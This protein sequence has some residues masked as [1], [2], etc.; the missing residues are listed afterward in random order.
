MTTYR[1]FAA[2]AMKQGK[3]LPEIGRAWREAHGGQRSAGG[4]HHE[5]RDQKLTGLLRAKVPFHEAL[6]RL[7]GMEHENPGFQ[8]DIDKALPWVLIGGAAWW[9]EKQTGFFGSLFGKL[10]G[11]L[12][13]L[14]SSSSA[15]TNLGS[16]SSPTTKMCNGMTWT[17]VSGMWTTT[18]LAGLQPPP[19]AAAP[20]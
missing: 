15:T 18:G 16:S 20:C 10:T 11:S 5:V 4:Q 12:S 9:V 13:N 2:H 6:R 3:S 14:G 19:Q 7:D 17:L 1:E 8:L